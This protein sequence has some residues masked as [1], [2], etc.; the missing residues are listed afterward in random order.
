MPHDGQNQKWSRYPVAAC[1]HCGPGNSMCEAAQVG[2][3]EE[4]WQVFCGA[5]GS[6]SGR[7]RTRE[8][9]E[10]LW[11]GR[12]VDMIADIRNAV[13]NDFVQAVERLAFEMPAP[14]EYTPRFVQLCVTAQQLIA[15]EGR[16]GTR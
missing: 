16:N 3:R 12:Y 5:C 14:N 6:S 11:N 9:A 13:L 8:E 4:W 7:C 1:P 10:K 15:A 2:Y